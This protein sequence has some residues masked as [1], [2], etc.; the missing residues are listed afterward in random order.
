M[1]YKFNE[2]K[3]KYQIKDDYS[4]Q[5]QQDVYDVQQKCLK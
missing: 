5:I 3:I 2:Q 1:R 4:A